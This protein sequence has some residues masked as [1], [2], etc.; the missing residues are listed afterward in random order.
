MEGGWFVRVSIIVSDD[1]GNSY[2]GEVE[3]VP[4]VKTKAARKRVT[5]GSQAKTSTR[6]SV[7]FS[8]HI[9]AFARRHARDMTGPR[10]FALLVAYLSKGESHKEVLVADVEKHW[11]K[12]KPLLGGKFNKAY[13][14]RAKE[15]GWVDS[16]KRGVYVVLPDWK[17]I[18]DA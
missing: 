2:Q 14:V 9:R 13:P 6:V 18:F 4:I 1:D 15:Y 3:L 16:P 7:N 17:G 11:N 10:R 8:A 5:G 12:M